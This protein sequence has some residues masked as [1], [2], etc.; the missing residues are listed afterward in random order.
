MIQNYEFKPLPKTILFNF[1]PKISLIKIFIFLDSTDR[2][3]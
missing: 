1:L 3:H 2:C